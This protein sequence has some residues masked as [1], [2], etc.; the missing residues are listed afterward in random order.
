LAET[1]VEKQGYGFFERLMIIF[2][3]VL[4]VIV[5]LL[6]LMTLF[7]V[8]FRNKALELG[9][10]V[11]VLKNVLPEP[12]V[13]GNS[14]DDD[15][16][17]SIKMTE[18]IE[19][20]EAELTALKSE[21][22]EANAGKQNLESEVKDLQDENARLKRL[23]EEEQLEDEQYTAKIGELAGMFARMSPGKAAPIV[24]N[25]EP[26]EIV[27]LFSAMSPDDRVRIME[28]M[29]PQIAAEAAMKL[30]DNVP[31]K[32]MQ[33]AALQARLDK[34]AEGSEAASS[35]TLDEQ[36]LNAT[37]SAMDA[38]SAGQ[39]LINMMAISPSKV[40]RILNSVDNSA[41]SA[42]LT[43]MSKIDEKAAAQIVT[44][45]MAGS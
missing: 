45:M 19:E 25:M 43:E 17:R 26:E 4:F 14:M 23:S 9:N 6:V 35:S 38:K 11:P 15:Q 3:P 1:E 44:K 5:L 22:A 41:R 18:K 27:L 10:S 31:A 2:V 13:A 20:L 34:Q 28:K 12:K 39:M 16:I 42:I 30:K 29:N 7:D 24:Q 40:L 21:L 32:D 33:L 37:F 36:Q 8:D